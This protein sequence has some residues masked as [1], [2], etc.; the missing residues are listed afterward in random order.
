MSRVLVDPVVHD[1]CIAWTDAD[2]ARKG[3]ALDE[4]ARRVD[5]LYLAECAE[6][7]QCRGLAAPAPAPA[8]RPAQ[9]PTGSPTSQ[10]NAAA[11]TASSAP[12]SASTSATSARAAVP[13]STTAPAAPRRY[14]C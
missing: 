14:A 8:G 1:D 13:G 4:A 9:R 12:A 10:A 3:I 7:G 6:T 5:V 11:P 2:T